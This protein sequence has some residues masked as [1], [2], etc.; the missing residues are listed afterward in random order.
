MKTKVVITALK[1]ADP[2]SHEAHARMRPLLVRW[3]PDSSSEDGCVVPGAL[4]LFIGC[5][6]SARGEQ[7]AE[8]TPGDTG[9][10]ARQGLVRGRAGTEAL[11]NWTLP[12]LTNEPPAPTLTIES[13]TLRRY[14]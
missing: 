7:E 14:Q 11:V 10:R 4:A 8:R 2:Q 12:D 9:P 6:V 5:I 1:A 13:L 3:F